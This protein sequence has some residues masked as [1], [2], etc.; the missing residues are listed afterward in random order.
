LLA[1]FVLIPGSLTIWVSLLLKKL[2]ATAKGHTSS[3]SQHS[4]GIKG[5]AVV[6]AAAVEAC[7]SG[8]SRHA[9]LS[10]VSAAAV[11]ALRPGNTGR[12]LASADG[13]L[14]LQ[15]P[16]MTKQQPLQAGSTG[17]GSAGH[18]ASGL[19]ANQQL[20]SG[21]ASGGGYLLPVECGRP[22]LEQLVK[23]WL[24]TQQQ[25][26]AM[27]HGGHQHSRSS[28][29]SRKQCCTV[30]GM[31]PERLVHEVQQLCDAVGGLQ[32]VRKTHQL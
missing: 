8:S 30:Y 24:A 4:Q 17:S 2:Q 23:S 26:L 16:A 21:A 15:L 5:E 7:S 22:P 9:A 12:L 6:P 10:A 13:R 19:G 11:D 29:S 18:E 3:Y 31:G 1:V 25:Q 32:F 28:R 14:Q 27:H 20:A